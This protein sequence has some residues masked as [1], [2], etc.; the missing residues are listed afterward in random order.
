[1]VNRVLQLEDLF[2]SLRSNI[3]NYPFQ[4]VKR[5]AKLITVTLSSS[6][7]K[8][9]KRVH[10][11][12]IISVKSSNFSVFRYLKSLPFILVSYTLSY[13]SD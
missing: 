10:I 13:I 9:N 4:N 12:F 3:I 1:M 11:L 5:L 2:R 7:M 8:V 6:K